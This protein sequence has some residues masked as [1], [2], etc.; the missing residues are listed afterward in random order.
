VVHEL[1]P[2]QI[3]EPSLTPDH[4]K[5]F[6]K[7]PNYLNKYK[8]EVEERAERLRRQE[9]EARMPPGTR[10]MGDEERLQTLAEL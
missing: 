7:V 2:P 9:E 1:H 5:N 4:H 10:L 8:Y 3:K 6:G